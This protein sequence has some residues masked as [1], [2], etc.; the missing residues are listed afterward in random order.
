M[1]RRPPFPV[2]SAL[3]FR[4]RQSARLLA[5]RRLRDALISVA[6]IVGK[7]VRISD[8][9]EVGRLGDLVARW[10]SAAPTAL[11]GSKR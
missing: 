10:D 8:R 1:A 9:A 3:R 7:P 2:R 11:D 5:S 4:D 6:G